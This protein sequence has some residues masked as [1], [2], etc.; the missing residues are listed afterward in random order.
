[1]NCEDYSDAGASWSA[2]AAVMEAADAVLV[3]EGLP[4]VRAVNGILHLNPMKQKGG[5]TNPFGAYWSVEFTADALPE[6]A[7]DVKRPPQVDPLNRSYC[8]WSNTGPPPLSFQKTTS[9]FFLGPADAVAIYGCTPPESRY[10]S[11]DSY[12]GGRLESDNGYIFY[13][14]TNFGDSLSNARINTTDGNPFAAPALVVQSF[15]G[16]VGRTVSEAFVSAGG[17][18]PAAT[19]VHGLDGSTARPYD[20]SGESG[21]DWT[22]ILPDF[23]L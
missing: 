14:G 3:G 21:D 2:A 22:T 23:L 16:K 18:D 10:Y 15:D 1:M 13:P 19:S 20:R 8:A 11:F 12:I 4:F 9:S 7:C 17:V 5:G 6:G